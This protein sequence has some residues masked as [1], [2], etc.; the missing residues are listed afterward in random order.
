MRVFRWSIAGREG[1][2]VK[3]VTL[4]TFGRT[5]GQEKKEMYERTKKPTK[6]TKRVVKECRGF[7]S[8]HDMN[9]ETGENEMQ[10]RRRYRG[11]RVTLPAD[12]SLTLSHPG[13]L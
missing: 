7:Q 1:A 5:N 4:A 9:G 12:L 10:R 13:P 8:K 2:S 3:P 6:R 11:G